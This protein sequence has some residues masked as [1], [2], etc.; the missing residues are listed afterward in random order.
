[1]RS[2]SNVLSLCPIDEALVD[3]EDVLH[4]D[5]F[6]S[7]KGPQCLQLL[8][9]AGPGHEAMGFTVGIL[10]WMPK[11]ETPSARTRP[12]S[13]KFS[14]FLPSWDST[15]WTQV[16]PENM[17][18][19]N[20]ICDIVGQ[21]ATFKPCSIDV[22]FPLTSCPPNLLQLFSFNTGSVQHVHV[23]RIPPNFSRV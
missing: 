16:K 17:T 23:L 10:S 1:M 13:T 11:L 15:H 9:S 4:I 3:L 8:E 18:S 14:M 21:C 7:S 12:R 5:W 2:N 6:H 22:F 20:L 19:R